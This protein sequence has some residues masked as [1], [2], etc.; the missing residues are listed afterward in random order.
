MF[1]RFDGGGGIWVFST[2]K[3]LFSFLEFLKALTGS[4]PLGFSDSSV[5]PFLKNQIWQGEEMTFRIYMITLD[6]SDNAILSLHCNGYILND[7]CK[8]TFVILDNR[9]TRHIIRHRHVWRQLFCLRGK[10]WSCKIMSLMA[11][12][13]LKRVKKIYFSR[14]NPLKRQW[15]SSRCDTQISTDF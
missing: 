3:R 10:L 5:F 6:H 8:I 15:D 4:F 11:D 14:T 9:F 13:F 7:S 1:C 2:K 12:N